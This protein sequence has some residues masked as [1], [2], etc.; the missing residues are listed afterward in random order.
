M[1]ELSKQLVR[2]FAEHNAYF[3]SE[4]SLSLYTSPKTD[5]DGVKFEKTYSGDKKSVNDRY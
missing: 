5:F 2:D 1:T 3:P 4:Y